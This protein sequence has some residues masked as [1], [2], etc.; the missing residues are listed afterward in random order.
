MTAQKIRAL[1]D[2]FPACFAVRLRYSYVSEL[3][4]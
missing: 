3:V 1:T 2:R 4:L